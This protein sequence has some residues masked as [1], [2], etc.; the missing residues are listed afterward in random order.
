M[1]GKIV[2]VTGA[3]SGIGRQTAI[4]FAKRRCTVIA[5]ARH[6]QTCQQTLDTINTLD[7]R[8]IFIPADMSESMSIANLFRQIADTCGRLDF[9]FNNAGITGKLGSMHKLGEM[10]FDEAISI[11][12]KSVWLCMKHEITL[13]LNQGH[14]RIVNNAS[15]SGVLAT[16]FGS[17]YGMTKHGVIG[18]TKSAA[19]EYAES[20]I[21]INVVCPGPFKTRM[22]DEVIAYGT[23]THDE[24]VEREQSFRTNVPVRRFG[25]LEEIAKTVVW[26]CSDDAGYIVGQSIIVDGGISIV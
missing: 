7:G 23:D 4:E 16:P 9:A 21:R 11:N 15:I 26:L 13:M 12:L 25:L 22:L 8:A 14:G 18:L 5:S 24:F 6:I 2:L 1:E 3:S 19:I 20:G 17:L 10:D